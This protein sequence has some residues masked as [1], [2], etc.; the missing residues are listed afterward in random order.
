MATS[1]LPPT[2]LARRTTIAM[3][4][5]MAGS[6][7]FFVLFVIAHM[8]GNLKMFGGKGAYDDYAAHLRTIGE[9]IL[10][11][12]GVLWIL[13]VLLLVS[14]L[15]HI[16]SAFYLWSRAQSARTTKYQVKK[17]MAATISA[18]FMRWGG[19]ALLLFIIWHLLQ[20]TTR[21]I[22]VN[23]SHDSPY[24]NYVAAFQ[25]SV[26]WVFVL[27]ALAMV[28]LAMHI[29]HGVWSASQT[30]GWTGNVRARRRANTLGIAL[31][32]VVSIGFILPAVFV[33][34]GVIK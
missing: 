26:W 21:T 31:A 5:V 20:F 24:D 18:R 23:G 25:P 10:P 34:F 6:G 28:A 30:L 12:S 11:Y 4:M 9:P 19:V 27:Y 15:A 7:I 14:V 1:T 3:K 32:A 22:N 2:I 13:R 17:A 29:R 8:Y 33:L 16:Y